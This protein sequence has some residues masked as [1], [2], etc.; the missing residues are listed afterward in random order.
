MIIL[1]NISHAPVLSRDAV[2]LI[3]V[4]HQGRLTALV[5][6]MD[7]P[8][9][10]PRASFARGSCSTHSLFLCIEEHH[11][12]FVAAVELSARL[13]KRRRVGT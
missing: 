10:A 11:A 3:C 2:R 6:L 7:C 9:E 12:G 8:Q 5:I 4:E 1:E 13:A